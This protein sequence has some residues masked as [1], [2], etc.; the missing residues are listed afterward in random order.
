MAQ[1]RLATKVTK[2]LSDARNV[3]LVLNQDSNGRVAGCGV[4]SINEMLATR[5]HMHP[6]DVVNRQAWRE[7]WD[8]V[9]PEEVIP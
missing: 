5:V 3:G 2:S 8:I 6:D 9:D 4:Q 1:L 7:E